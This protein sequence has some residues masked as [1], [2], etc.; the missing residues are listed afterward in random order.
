MSVTSLPS[1]VAAAR[2]LLEEIPDE[3]G[4]LRAEQL[5]NLMEAIEFLKRLEDSFHDERTDD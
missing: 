2:A 5:A 1:R 3:H 4:D